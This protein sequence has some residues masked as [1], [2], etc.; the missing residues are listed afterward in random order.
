MRGSCE[1]G[2]WV[3]PGCG[4][5]LRSD[6]GGGPE[7]VVVEE[8]EAAY[9]V[10]PPA[11]WRTEVACGPPGE[12]KGEDV[13]EQEIDNGEEEEGGPAGVDST[14]DACWVGEKEG[15]VGPWWK[16]GST[17]MSRRDMGW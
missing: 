15:G 11:G 5:G 16:G 1:N 14:P 9:A 6:G 4:S 10:P 8:E 12:R 7:F 13:I 3:L 2:S 17:A